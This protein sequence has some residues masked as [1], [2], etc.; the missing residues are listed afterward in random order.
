M[1]SEQG[2]HQDTAYVVTSSPLELAAAWIA[3]EDVQPGSGEL[4]Y[5]DGSHR[6]PEYLFSGAFK[7]WNPE[8]DGI[9]QHAEWSRLLHANAA[10]LG[11]ALKTFRPRQGD[12]F[13]WSAD[14]AHGGMP[15]ERPESTRHS[16]VGHYCPGRVAPHYFSTAPDHRTTTAYG[17]GRY[18]SV[19]YRLA[20]TAI[21]PSS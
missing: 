5:Y 18:S 14:L 9:E 16:L 19:H 4:M 10:R 20:P 1:G 15:V 6:L 7:H 2:I 17:G 3:L 13:L 8:R 12:V 21:T 11:L